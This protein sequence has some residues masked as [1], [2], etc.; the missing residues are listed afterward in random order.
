MLEK[1]L[2]SDFFKASKVHVVEVNY[3][4]AEEYRLS[5]ISVFKKKGELDWEIFEQQFADVSELKKKLKTGVPICISIVGKGI[6][7]RVFNEECGGEEAVLKAIPNMNISEFY[8]NTT[9]VNEQTLLAIT[10]KSIVE[11]VF[12]Q[13]KKSGFRILDFAVGPVLINQSLLSRSYDELSLSANK[14]SLDNNSISGIQ[15]E[16][17]CDKM[18]Y[19]IGNKIIES[20]DLNTLFLGVDFFTNQLEREV[21]EDLCDSF[22]KE[23]GM[24]QLFDKAVIVL[25]LFYFTILLGNFF[26]KDYYSVEFSELN[27][28]MDFNIQKMN[29]LDKLKEDL[30]HKKNLLFSSGIMNGNNIT[31]FSDQIA[32][33]V[34]DGIVLNRMNVAPVSEKNKR[35]RK[36]KKLEYRKELILLEGEAKNAH[37]FNNWVRD[38]KDFEWLEDLNIISYD[39]NPKTGWSEFLIEINL[40]KR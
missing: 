8:W 22:G 6:I 39:R 11:E 31:M 17:H 18:N 30:E 33:S 9:E 19:Q 29:Q 32:E 4:S 2:N 35:R 24:K 37:S 25:V 36:K 12:G 5:A 26:V 13:F 7:T 15:N 3:L 21:S 28:S 1:F 38:L 14:I 20:K 23:E 27:A 34:R 40:K 16:D 10:R